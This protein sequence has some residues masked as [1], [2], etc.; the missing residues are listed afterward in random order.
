[1]KRSETLEIHVLS[2][3]ESV[4]DRLETLEDEIKVENV[5]I[6][7]NFASQGHLPNMLKSEENE[8][9]QN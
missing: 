9:S 3:V 1:M 7:P 6:Q 2:G 8:K 4:A 5:D